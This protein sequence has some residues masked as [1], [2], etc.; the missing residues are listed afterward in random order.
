MA[1]LINRNSA[2][3][4]ECLHALV[5]YI[6]KVF[7]SN[8]F[9]M[10]EIK[11]KREEYN[12]YEFCS[13]LINSSLKIKYCPYKKNPLSKSGCSLTNGKDDDTTKSKEVS[14][15]I[16]ALHALG[17]ANRKDDEIKLTS[18]GI[19][20]AKTDYGTANMQKIIADAVLKYGPVIGVLK[21]IF[22]CEKCGEFD[23]NDINVGYPATE[24]IISF[25]GK[26][27]KIS[28]GSKS[29]SNT[30]TKSCILAWL[31]TAG[32]IRPENQPI[33]KNC[34]FAHIA[35]RSFLNQ[36]T[37]N[38]RKYV[39]VNRINFSSITPFVT[40]RPL[41]Y[42]NLTKL[43]SAL[44][45]NNI[46]EIREATM[47]F[48]PRINNRRLA[49][50]YFLNKAYEQKKSLKLSFVI[51]FFIKNQDL[52]IITNKSLKDTV[53]KEL[54][55][56]NMAGIP[57]VVTEKSKE[58]YLNPITKINL[59]ELFFDAPQDIIKVLEKQEII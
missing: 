7:G 57:F 48:E 31:T 19:K 40:E 35:Y 55:I 25:N 18:F 38:D 46:A 45:E 4:I 6:Y 47:Y 56:A 30:R 2:A 59:K 12:V 8:N 49:I 10:K 24:E 51:D 13:M 54:E 1:Y 21:Q 16:N 42:S 44:R 39:V 22:E 37:R 32:F 15:T 29:D 3:R 33:L 36:S 28:T 9:S 58:I 34:E 20:F 23:T 27:V 11:F 53:I 17:F 41:N 43:N 14:N 52:F 50:I 26:K 5:K